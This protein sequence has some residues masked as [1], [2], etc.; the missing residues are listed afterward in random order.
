MSVA[1]QAIAA[2]RKARI[3]PRYARLASRDAIARERKFKAML[4]R[5]KDMA[6]RKGAK[7]G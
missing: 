3:D 7:K 2:R 5:Q 1:A 6:A 4:Q